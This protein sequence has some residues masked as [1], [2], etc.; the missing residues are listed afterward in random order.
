[1]AVLADLARDLTAD[2]TAA[3]SHYG[4]DSTYLHAV[5]QDRS[6]DFQ[7]DPQFQAFSTKCRGIVAAL[8]SAIAASRLRDAASLYAAHGNGF[9]VRGSLRGDPAGF[10]GLTYQYPGFISTTAATEFRDRFLQ[11]RRGSDS[12]PTVLE[13]RLPVG[14]NAIDMHHG[15]H[16]GE[17]EFLLGRK[18]PFR[19]TDSTLV[20]HDILS[21]VLEPQS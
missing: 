20:D 14:F 1:M 9:G 4:A 13:L 6:A 10:I 16:A 5:F 18:I 11:P 17:F 15:N 21:F 3:L 2:E 12:H 7:H 8:D 19:I